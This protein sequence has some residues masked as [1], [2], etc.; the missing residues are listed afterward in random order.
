MREIFERN[1]N[2]GHH[3]RLSFKGVLKKMVRSIVGVFQS[4]AQ[5]CFSNPATKT[6][7][8]VS[9]YNYLL[10]KAFKK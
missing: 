8:V 5:V 6:Y 2:N 1:N 4:V 10:H 3:Y 9:V 7:R